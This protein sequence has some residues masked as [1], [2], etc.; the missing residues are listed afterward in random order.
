MSST[1]R[2]ARGGGIRPCRRYELTEDCW[3]RVAPRL[4]VQRRGGRWAD[5]RTLLSGVFGFS[6]AGHSGVMRPDQYWH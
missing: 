6:V 5:H 4:P 1:T 3:E 2:T